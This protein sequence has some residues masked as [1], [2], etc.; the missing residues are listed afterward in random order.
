MLAPCA[1][2]VKCLDNFPT[3]PPGS[4][5]QR[6]LP[7][8]QRRH[9]R[10]ARLVRA[11]TTTAAAEQGGSVARGNS[12]DSRDP[13]PHEQRRPQLVEPPQLDLLQLRPRNDDALLRS[14]AHRRSAQ[15]IWKPPAER[16]A[17]VRLLEQLPF[18][19]PAAL[20][21]C[22]LQ[23]VRRGARDAHPHALP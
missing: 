14:R 1:R 6:Q 2:S 8:E 15:L 18:D 23:A 20:A 5:W 4:L 16:D 17:A 22:R 19:R 10:N 11:A 9:H 13:C 7:P 21:E 3:L 12:D